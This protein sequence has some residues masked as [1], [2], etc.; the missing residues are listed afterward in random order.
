MISLAIP[1]YNTS[2]YFKD[3]VS[4]SINNDFVSEIVVTDDG[5]TDQ[6]W[7]NI[8][9]IIKD[10]E[11]DKF[12]LY[13][14]EHNLGGFKNK[15]KTVENSTSDWVYLLDSDNH[16]NDDTL[17]VIESLGELDPNICYS[18][19]SLLLHKDFE[20]EPY[21]IVSYDFGYDLISMHEAQDA[22]LKKTKYFDWFLN[23]GN[24]VFNRQKYL[25]R[26]H[27]SYTNNEKTAAA[28]VCAFS[29]HWLRDN[30]L[31]KIVPDM[32]YFHRVRSDSYWVSEASSSQP[33][34]DSY[35]KK[36]IDLEGYND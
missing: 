33:L 31:Y 21:D 12:K 34:S 6:E 20:T 26:M 16:P 10:S 8:N 32:K 14:N 1:F 5:S 27:D 22:L 23:T 7:D 29:Y 30:G 17:N 19:F 35:H 24:F 15:Y 13:R 9:N 4:S 36:I 28:D 3:A 25:E 11:S 2:R 18:P